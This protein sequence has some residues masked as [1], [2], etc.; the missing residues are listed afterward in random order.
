[1]VSLKVTFSA[2]AGVVDSIAN[3]VWA[4]AIGKMFPLVQ[5][6]FPGHN[7]SEIGYISFHISPLWPPHLN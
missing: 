7:G 5:I 1:M 2:G 4:P 3:V 6:P